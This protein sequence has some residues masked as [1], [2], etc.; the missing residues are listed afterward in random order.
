MFVLLF[1]ILGLYCMIIKRTDFP[2]DTHNMDVVHVT[3][4]I[5]DHGLNIS[6]SQVEAIEC[7]AQYVQTDGGDLRDPDSHWLVS[8]QDL[9]VVLTAHKGILHD[10]TTTFQYPPWVPSV[11][12]Q[13][14]AS[15]AKQ[16]VDHTRV[17]LG[18]ECVWNDLI[19]TDKDTDM[20]DVTLGNSTNP[21]D[22]T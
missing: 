14:W 4:W 22:L 3:V 7:W 6:N 11:F 19:S 16:A 8:P 2:F 15:A 5:Q 1:S 17:Q 10:V 9:H 21:G 18:M 13:N 12:A 20:V